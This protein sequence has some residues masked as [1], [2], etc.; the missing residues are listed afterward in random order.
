M[1]IDVRISSAVIIIGDILSPILF[2]SESDIDGTR[3][4]A[5]MSIYIFI[6]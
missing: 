3:L 6:H 1:I 4:L 2:L 5:S